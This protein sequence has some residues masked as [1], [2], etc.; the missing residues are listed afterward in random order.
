MLYGGARSSSYQEMVRQLLRY[1][2]YKSHCKSSGL[3]IASTRAT[4]TASATSIPSS[5]STSSVASSTSPTLVAVS[6][7]G[8][9]VGGNIPS[10]G[11]RVEVLAT[12]TY[13]FFVFGGKC[14]GLT[15]TLLHVNFLTI[16]IFLI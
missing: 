16:T 6:H 7:G 3:T 12:N 9:S 11:I 15:V 4:V 8:L 5:H 1:P 10:G 2:F 14:V 13:V